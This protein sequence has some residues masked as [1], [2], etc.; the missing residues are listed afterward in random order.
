M[1]VVTIQ[2]PQ[3]SLTQEKRNA[4]VKKVTDAVVEAEE[5]PAARPYVY[6]L[7][8]EIADGGWGMGGKAFTL[9]DLK[10]ALPRG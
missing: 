9:A 4:M 10:S 6:V 2:V 7:I 8:Q 1:P 5:L 3:G